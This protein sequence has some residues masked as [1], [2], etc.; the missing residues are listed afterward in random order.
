[1]HRLELAN[2]MTSARELGTAYFPEWNFLSGEK[3][4][5]KNW[6]TRIEIQQIQELKLH[7]EMRGFRR[8]FKIPNCGFFKTL[9]RHFCGF[10]RFEICGLSM[11]LSKHSNIRSFQI[12]KF[13]SSAHQH[14]TECTMYNYI[15]F[16]DDILPIPIYRRW[17]NINHSSYNDDIGR[18]W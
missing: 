11:N 12:L 9:L 5:I 10:K 15:S 1:M 16:N 8:D 3:Q 4:W 6:K 14:S 13:H 17:K 7:W 2:K 18:G